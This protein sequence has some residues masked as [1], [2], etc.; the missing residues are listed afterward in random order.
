MNNMNELIKVTYDNDRPIHFL[1]SDG[2]PDT[3][4]NTCWTQKGRMMIHNLLARR[5]IVPVMDRKEA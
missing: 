1:H 4:M 5:G 2:R 3:K